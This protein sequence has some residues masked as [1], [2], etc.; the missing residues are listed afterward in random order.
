MTDPA[1]GDPFAAVAA[2]PEV[3]EAVDAARGAVDA[4]LRDLRRPE[5]RRRGREVT[6]ESMRRSARASVLLETGGAGGWDVP[7]FVPPFATDGPGRTASGALR[8]YAELQSLVATWERAPLQVLARLHTLAAADLA[9]DDA[10]GRPTSP[11]ASSRLAALAELLVVGTAAP[12]LVPAAVV[13]GELLVLAPFG[14]A[15]GVVA[16]AATRLVLLARGLDPSGAIVPEEGQLELGAERYAAALSGYRSG[17]P[18]GVAAWVSYNAQSVAL[19]AAAG[20]RVAETVLAG[21]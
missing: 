16:R 10:L 13:H 5:L 15:D 14:T 4:L 20:R 12:A 9:E 19:G 21:I 8:V 18:E 1:G 11:G 6:A 3:F 2:L 17:T 7:A